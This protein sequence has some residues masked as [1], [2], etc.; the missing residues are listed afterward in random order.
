MPIAHLVAG[1][2]V[3]SLAFAAGFASAQAYPV[4]PIR[5]V[6]GFP[7]GTTVDVLARPIAQRMTEALGQQLI[8]DN[9]AGATGIIANELVAR[10]APDGYTLLATP[11][12]SL[13]TSPH[14]H[15][16]MTF[17]PL[18]DLLPIVQIGEFSQVLITHPAVP[19]RTV[20]ELIALAR[21]KPGV[22]TYGSTGI[23]SGFH[24]GGELFANMAKINVIHVP[25]K[26]GPA[27]VTDM[28][29]GRID[30][31]FYSF[32]V[33]QPQV[34]AGRLRV[35]AVTGRQR[36]PTLPGVPTVSEAG[37][38]GF[39]IGGWHGFFAP[40]GTAKEIIERLNALVLRILAAPD[41]RELWASQGMAIPTG[42]PAQFAARVRDDYEKFG[43][44]IKRA[45]I[46]AE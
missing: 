17:D 41:M 23:G 1:M 13:T 14:L 12:S 19:A 3:A 30:F 8:L 20:R 18:R 45:G 37:L 2:M 7:P 39:E 25:Y 29:G 22:L 42:N 28:L 4:K 15:T 9:R 10:A 32:A 35:I 5:I 16:K 36:D 11:G 24:L 31:M 21:A 33:V 40:A 38:P 6:M 46:K 44:L 26:G 34:K 27:A 43:A